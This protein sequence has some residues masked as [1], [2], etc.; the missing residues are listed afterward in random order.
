[1]IASLWLAV[2]LAWAAPPPMGPD[3]ADGPRWAPG[4]QPQAMAWHRMAQAGQV[5]NAVGGSAGFVT[6]YVGSVIHL[7]CALDDA[8]APGEAEGVTSAGAA[9]TT[10]SMGVGGGL[11]FGGSLSGHT[12][13]L[14]GEGRPHGTRAVTG[15][16]FHA[17]SMT[18]LGGAVY[19][20]HHSDGLWDA[21]TVVGLTS[22]GLVLWI[23]S[24]ALGGKQLLR[25]RRMLVGAKGRPAVQLAPLLDPVSLSVGITGRW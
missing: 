15:L 19:V 9:L 17:A 5:V 21:V 20:A 13:V 12:L 2:S 4:T 7:G 11:M 22:G 8:C 1:M 23:T 18:L 14:G 10:L 25:D 6:M 24:T 16:A 3:P